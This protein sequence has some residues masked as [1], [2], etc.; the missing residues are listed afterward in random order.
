MGFFKFKKY[1]GEGTLIIFSVLFALFINKAFESYQTYK[2]K[3]VALESI[4]MELYRNQAI[5]KRWKGKHIAIRDR[6]IAL[7]NGEEDSLKQVM[8]SKNYLDLGLLTTDESLMDA[9]L[10]NTAWESAKQTGII[11]E[12]DFETIQ[13]LTLVYKMQGVLTDRT[14]AKILDYYFDTSS[15]DMEKLDQ[16]LIQF[17][18]LFGELSGQEILMVTL[19]DEAL[20]VVRN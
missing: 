9:L 8:A 19:Y 17:Q 13:K 14:L 3:Q 11:A 6:L 20:K 1:L 12:F 4:E 10:T 16:V 2:R 15:H 5:M 18:L 7:T